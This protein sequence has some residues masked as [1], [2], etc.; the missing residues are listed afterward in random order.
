MKNKQTNSLI[1]TTAELLSESVMTTKHLDGNSMMQ[2]FGIATQDRVFY[3][4]SYH[5][6]RGQR[7]TAIF[8]IGINKELLDG[9]VKRVGF[10]GIDNQQPLQKEVQSTAE[11]DNGLWDIE[12]ELYVS[13][14]GES[15]HQ[16]RGSFF[17]ETINNTYYWLKDKNLND[18]EFNSDS[19]LI[20]KDF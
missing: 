1:N 9:T 5:Q 10:M 2:I 8:T 13:L 17:V 16:I 7:R 18:F 15:Y 6:F 19:R 4:G 11:Y 20:L 12:F 14:L 3:D